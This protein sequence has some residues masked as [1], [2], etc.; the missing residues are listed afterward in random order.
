MFAAREVDEDLA[1]RVAQR[2]THIDMQDYRPPT[3]DDALAYFQTL[4]H[5]APG[6]DGIPHARWVAGGE[7][8]ARTIIAIT[9]KLRHGVPPPADFCH[10]YQELP[11]KGSKL[12]DSERVVRTAEETRPLHLKKL[13]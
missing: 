12:E 10:S 3:V 1:H 5:S 9:D 11:P 7:D 6:L 8:A 4:Q 13:G 2:Q